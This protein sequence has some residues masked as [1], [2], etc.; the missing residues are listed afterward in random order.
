MMPHNPL[1][2]LSTAANIHF[3]AA[4]PNYAYLEDR[5]E[6]FGNSVVFPRQPEREG[7]YY[8]VPSL[9]EPGL[10]VEV[11]EEWVIAAAAEGFKWEA[12]GH[13][14]TEGYRRR[15]GSYTNE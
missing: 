3:A 12:G 11:N 8:P 13:R 1:G 4:V 14:S 5:P 6:Y 10:G 15:D 7:P 9:D 2:P